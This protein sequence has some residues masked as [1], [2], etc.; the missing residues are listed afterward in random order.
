MAAQIRAR[1]E[2]VVDP[3]ALAVVTVPVLGIVG[4]ADPL[5]RRYLQDFV[6]IKAGTQLVVIE[7]ATHGERTG[8]P[9]AAAYDHPQFLGAIREFLSA[10]AQREN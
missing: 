4:S 2:L 7:G 1:R 6:K 9:G 5:G 8:P 10:N 3:K